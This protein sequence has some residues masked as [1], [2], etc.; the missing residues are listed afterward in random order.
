MDS[1]DGGKVLGENKRTRRGFEYV[2]FQDANDFECTLQQSSA[3]DGTE[4]GMQHPGT[5]FV[6]L[7]RENSERMHLNRDHV[8]GLVDRLKNWLDHGHFKK[9]GEPK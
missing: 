2:E 1:V 5:S 9:D 7:G 8:L 4:K 6:W 3:I